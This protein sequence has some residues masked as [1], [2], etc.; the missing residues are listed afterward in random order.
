MGCS[1]RNIP[2]YT[3]I[4]GSSHLDMWGH[5]INNPRVKS[6]TGETRVDHARPPHKRP[7]PPKAPGSH[8]G[9]RVCPPLCVEKTEGPIPPPLLLTGPPY[10]PN[11]PRRVGGTRVNPLHGG[12]SRLTSPVPPR[13]VPIPQ[14]A[15]TG[16][17]GLGCF[18][19]CVGRG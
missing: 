7:Y 17:E 12:P 4:V 11:G 6:K 8:V 19:R 2:S 5:S 1:C 13:G 14:T 16:L 18:R 10:P 3:R 15:H 9:L